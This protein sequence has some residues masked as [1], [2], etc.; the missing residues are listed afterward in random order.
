VGKKKN[1]INAKDLVEQPE[2]TLG[3]EERSRKNFGP[4]WVLGDVTQKLEGKNTA[5]KDVE[6]NDI[7]NKPGFLEGRVEMEGSFNH[8]GNYEDGGTWVNNISQMA[9]PGE[10]NV[11]GRKKTGAWKRKIANPQ[12]GGITGKRLE[13]NFIIHR[14]KKKSKMGGEEQGR[15]LQRGKLGSLQ[16]E[17]I[18]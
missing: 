5:G 4:L 17:I 11:S 1:A 8:R 12:Q 10:T 15:D 6:E 9:A 16:L 18:Q 3:D 13:T 7:E 14:G 2:E